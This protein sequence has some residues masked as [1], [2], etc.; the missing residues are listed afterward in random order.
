MNK[1]EQIFR[2]LFTDELE[3]LHFMLAN[4]VIIDNHEAED[5]ET[6]ERHLVPFVRVVD[7]KNDKHHIVV[8]DKPSYVQY[9]PRRNIAHLDWIEGGAKFTRENGKPVQ[10][11]IEFGETVEFAYEGAGWDAWE[12]DDWEDLFPELCSPD[13]NPVGMATLIVDTDIVNW[14]FLG[15]KS[16]IAKEA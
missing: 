9:S 11:R 3:Y 14:S 2:S 12:V 8:S 10:V 7:K 13:P 16:E 5:E 6:G 15:R 4:K 1:A